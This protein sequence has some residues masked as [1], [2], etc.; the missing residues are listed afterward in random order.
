MFSGSIVALVT[1]M[2]ADGSLDIDALRRLVAW[3]IEQGTQALVA[4]GTTG[5]FSA[6]TP[7]EYR[8]VIRA[9]VEESAH[10]I[11]VIAGSGTSCTQKTI[12]LTQL[13]KDLGVDACLLLT[14]CGIKPTQ[15][16]LIAHYLKIAQSVAI[17]QLLYNVPTR[18]ACDLLPETVAQIAQHPHVVGIKECVSDHYSPLMNTLGQRLDILSGDDAS[19]LE[20]FTLGGHGV[21]SVVANVV[22]KLM[23]TFWEAA[24]AGQNDEAQRLQHSLQALYDTLFLEANPI[25]VKWALHEMGAIGSEIRLPLTP[26]SELYRAKVQEALRTLKCL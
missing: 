26:L 22:P 15:A 10:R 24:K 7:E 9:V 1:P 21:I 8:I 20:L 13:A 23:R 3:H 12:E 18:T 2:H 25:P 4:A 19:A 16:G 11:P 5:E 6:L 14:P 17:P